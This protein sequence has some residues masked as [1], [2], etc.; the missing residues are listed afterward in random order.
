MSST[1]LQ[2]VQQATAEMGLAVPVAVASSVAAD[3]VQTLALMNATGYELIRIHPWE[4]LNQEYRF[5]TVFYS[6]TGN[7]AS[8]STTISGMSSTTGLDTTFAVLGTGINQDTYVVSVGGGNVVLSQAA[9]A[10]GTA[11]TLT[12]CQIRYTL[13]SDFDRLT[14]RTQWDKSK[15]WEMI[16][17]ETPQQWQWLKSGYISTGPRIRFRIL[18]NLFQIWPPVSTNEFIGYEYVSNAF[19]ISVAGSPKSSFTLDTDTCIFTDRLMVLGTKKKYFEIK[20][21]DTTALTRDYQHHLELEKSMDSSS[22]T[23]SMAPRITQLLI[24]QQNI[25]DS[26]YGS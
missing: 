8:G 23:L 25:P 16:G 9:T 24:D 3:T 17:P 4:R 2:L 13:P 12:F 10:S 21:F 6:Y 5:T 11:V 20:G 15:H 22:P 26:S 7:V 18:N 1:M 14:D 19:A